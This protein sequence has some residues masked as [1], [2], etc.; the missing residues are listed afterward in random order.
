MTLAYLPSPIVRANSQHKGLFLSLPI[1]VG[2]LVKNV[3]SKV[4]IEIHTTVWSTDNTNK[5]HLALSAVTQFIRKLLWNQ[6]GRLEQ[7]RH[8][9]SVWDC[10]PGCG[11]NMCHGCG[12]NMCHGLYLGVQVPLLPWSMQ[13][14]SR[15]RKTAPLVSQCT[16]TKESEG[17]VR[18][19]HSNYS[20]V[21]A[22]SRIDF[23]SVVTNTYS[24]GW[25]FQIGI[26]NI[27]TVSHL[28][29]CLYT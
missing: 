18:I 8:F 13:F 6:Q 11:F 26:T 21:T 20:T 2:D 22:C 25:N 3:D 28:K 15:H 17:K 12:Y 27:V 10:L 5:K 16:L 14:F 1:C 19:H 23:S 7:C 4:F 9:S 29:Y 24:A